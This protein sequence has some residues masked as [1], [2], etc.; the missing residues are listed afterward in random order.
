VFDFFSDRNPYQL[1]GHG[2]A[3][4]TGYS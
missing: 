4:L 1:K 2:P 3:E